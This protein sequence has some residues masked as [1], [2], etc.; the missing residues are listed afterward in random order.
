MS[1]QDKLKKIRANTPKEIKLM[2]D[3][4][5]AIVDRIDEIMTKKGISQRQLAELLGKRESEVSK[6]MRGTHNFTIKTIAKLEAVL[7]E[8]IFQIAPKSPVVHIINVQNNSSQQQWVVRG[9]KDTAILKGNYTLPA[10]YESFMVN[11]VMEQ[12]N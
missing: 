12:Y 2:I 1:I 3:H 11:E 5:F 9:V 7:G 4:S 10:S 6:W 8:P